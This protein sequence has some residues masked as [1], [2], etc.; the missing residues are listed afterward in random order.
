[1]EAGDKQ[2]VAAILHAPAYLSGLTDKQMEALRQRAAYAFA[3]R[4]ST[5]LEAVRNASS[6]VAAAGS[7]LMER[8]DRVR[9]MS[10]SAEGHT[11]AK[12]K[13]LSEIGQ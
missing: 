3:P 10:S 13:T 6:M 7:R 5:Q 8:F 9:A 11:R 1:V 2:T 4:E 12:I